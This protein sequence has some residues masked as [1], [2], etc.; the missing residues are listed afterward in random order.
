MNKN[1]INA[2]TGNKN[3]KNTTINEINKYV[4]IN[5]VCSFICLEYPK[6][7]DIAPSRAP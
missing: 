4:K 1:K 7:M 6:V 3:Q 5:N 2:K